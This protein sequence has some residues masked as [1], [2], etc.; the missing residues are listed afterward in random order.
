MWLG[1]ARRSGAS[2]VLVVLS[3]WATPAR[4]EVVPA[5]P[6]SPIVVALPPGAPGVEAQITLEL[7]IDASGH[8]ESAVELSRLPR[9]TP[10]AAVAAAVAA[11]EASVFTPSTR[12]G[13]PFRSRIE[14]VAVLRAPSDVRSAPS[15]SP[16]ATAPA[17]APGAAP[18]PPAEVVVKSTGWVS[19]RGLGD[20]RVDR[21]TLT[22]SPRERTSEMLSAIP[23]FFVDHEDGEGLGND[24][25]LRG[26]DLDNGSGIEMKVGGIPTNIP[27]HIHGQGYADVNFIIPEVVESIRAIEG[28]Y[29]PRQGDAAIVG[30][31]LF[32]LGVQER[33][34]QAKASYGSFGQARVV[35]IAAPRDMGSESFAAFALRETRG[36]GQDRASK[37]GSVNAQ[38]GLELNDTDHVR[39]LATAY[40]AHADLPGV[41]RKDDVDAG[42]IDYYGAYPYFNSVYPANCTSPSCAEPAQG[43]SSARVMLGAELD[44][45][46]PGRAEFTLTPW[47]MWTNFLSR[48]N[49]TGAL[50]SSNL[51]PALPSQ[52]DLWQLT[53]LETAGGLSA[54]FRTL[55]RH[56]GRF[57]EFTS[58]SGV[59]LRLGHTDQAKELVNPENLA[60]W[61]YRENFGLNTLDLAAYVDV[62]ARLAKT[63]RVSG[64]M[65][66]DFLDVELDDR[67]AGVVPPIPTGALPGTVMN[68]SGVAP[69][70]RGTVAFEALPELTPVVSAGMGFRSLDA[71]SLTLCNASNALPTSQLPPCRPGSP[72]S[73][74]TSFEAGLRSSVDR[75]K[76]TSTLT[77]FQTDVANELTFAVDEGGL[78]TERASTRR[79]VV[80]SMLARPLPWLL[81]STALSV[82][83][84]TFDT[85]VAGTSHYV[86]NVP[87]ILWRADVN[88]HGTLLELSG[89]PLTGRAGVGY[90]LIGGRHV[91]DRIVSPTD[92]VLNA[93][94][95]LRYGAVE[96]GCD[97]YN[98]LGLEYADDTQYFLSNW[99][100]QPGQQRASGAVHIVA[101]APRTTLGTLTLYL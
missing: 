98:V 70:P 19:S 90:T 27:L 34:Y 38:Y 67:L 43:V 86:T 23:G 89:A 74:V 71:G 44:H 53:N 56:V 41:L 32:D 11:V 83:T 63:L 50:N 64:G 73:R 62:D 13:R 84:A 80:G 54:S 3:T 40:S 5:E 85:L 59:S 68:V 39:L 35:G 94:A 17:A 33:G 30:S 82:Q 48:Q 97:M 15:P 79:G 6:R 4:A 45:V 42:R 88:A 36:F 8:V 21:E 99:S 72:Y 81:A 12:D 7:V 93:L 37:S 47:L 55:P 16:S 29:D 51:E 14:Y 66:V 46:E 2:A 77:V 65:R 57:V 75:G 25:Y 18:A 26:F 9:D 95:S 61:D 31:A 69:G 96:L 101:A 92:N 49:Y 24:V 60:P 10:D 28:P 78:E 52:G 76:F 20:V 87:A 22:A 100:F 1:R 91:N 58:E